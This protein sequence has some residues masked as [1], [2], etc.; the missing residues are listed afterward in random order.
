MGDH[1]EIEPEGPYDAFA[2]HIAQFEVAVTGL[3][4]WPAGQE[5]DLELIVVF[6]EMPGNGLPK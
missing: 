2:T 4:V 3:T 5:R 6:A 1:V